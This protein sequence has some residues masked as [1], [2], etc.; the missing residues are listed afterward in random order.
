MQFWMLSCPKCSRDFVHSKI[1]LSAIEE[2]RRDTFR[3][4]PKRLFALEGQKLT[5][6]ECKT[7]SAFQRHQMFYRDD[8]PHF[9]F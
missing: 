4:L 1:E 9:P 6:P 3:I 7:E 8:T 2:A 5:C